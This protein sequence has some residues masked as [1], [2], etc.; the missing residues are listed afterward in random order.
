M[1]STHL[2]SYGGPVPYERND[3]WLGIFRGIADQIVRSLQ[4]RRVFDAGCAKGF[5]V[6]ALWE[7]GVE[8]QGIDISEYAISQVRKDIQAFCLCASLTAPIEG[9]FDLVTCFE[10]LEH[11]PKAEERQILSNLTAIDTI[12]F[13]TPTESA[14]DACQRPPDY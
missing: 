14:S 13:P 6:E 3:Y 11:I 7:R 8:A 4:P 9:R 12:L 5:L 1:M 10:V 2:E